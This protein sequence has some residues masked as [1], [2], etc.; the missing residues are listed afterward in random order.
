MVTAIL[1]FGFIVVLPIL[2][3]LASMA[4]HG[5]FNRRPSPVVEELTQD[6]KEYLASLGI[7]S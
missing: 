1:L 3:I 4:D 6:Q 5:V 7:R 2:Q